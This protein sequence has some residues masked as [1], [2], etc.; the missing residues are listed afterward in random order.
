MAKLNWND[1]K[2]GRCAVHCLGNTEKFSLLLECNNHGIG[3]INLSPFAIR[4]RNYFLCS[5][6]NG[7]I[8]LFALTEGQCLFR[9]LN[10]VEW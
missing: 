1:F 3:T 10:V 7:R 8:E 4:D 9:G 5:R 2:M 6:S